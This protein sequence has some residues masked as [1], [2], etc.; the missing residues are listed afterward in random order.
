MKNFDTFCVMIDMSRNAV[1]TKDSLKTYLKLLKKMGYNS[2]M[3]YTEDTYEV[4]NEPYMGYMRSRYTKEDLKELKYAKQ[5]LFNEIAGLEAIEVDEDFQIAGLDN[6]KEWLYEKKT[7]MD[8]TKKEE[9]T[10]AFKK[11][12]FD[13]IAEKGFFA[14]VFPVEKEHNSEKKFFFDFSVKNIAFCYRH[15]ENIMI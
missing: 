5:M 6:L 8:P 10:D 15:F 4:N 7:L 11:T 13:W 3:L 14:K 9:L 12:A 1:M 2:A